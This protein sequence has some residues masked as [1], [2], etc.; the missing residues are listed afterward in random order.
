MRGGRSLLVLLVIALGLGA[1]I[2]FV[3]SERDP[4]GTEPREKVFTV[5]RSAVTSLRI[6]SGTAPATLLQRSGETWTVVEPVSA[7]A[8]VPTVD[9]ILSSLETMEVD[10]VLEESPSSVA[11]YGLEPPALEVT[12]T[13]TGGTSRTLTLGNTAPTGSGMYARSSESARLLMVPAYLKATFDKSTFDL[14]RRDV[15]DVAREAV[16]RITIVPKG[17][18]A[19]ELRREAVNWRLVSPVEARA[20]FSAVD[21]LVDRLASAQMASIA[22]EGGE[23]TAAQLRTF[24]LDAPQ[25]T[26]ALAS[27]TTTASIVFGGAAGDSRVFARDLSR[28]I[29]FTVDEALV[30]DL[31]PSADDLRVKDI[32]EFNALSA[33][34]LETAYGGATLAFERAAPSEGSPDLPSWTRTRPTAGEVN[35]TALTDLLNALSSLRAERF[36]GQAPGS[37]EDITVSVTFGTADAPR[38]EQATLRR[39]GGSVYAIR[40]GEAG[41]AIISAGEFDTVLG[42]LKTLAPSQQ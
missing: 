12:F 22:H 23:P 34:R 30:T 7:S 10:R 20:E 5:D 37:G 32:F 38:Q 40:P 42:H 31:G 6:R 13:T 35:Q 4:A 36:V 3:E 33:G 18:P 16:D 29:V 41:A 25:L 14:R 26:A 9:A 2:Y 11:A 8:D 28:P 15:L 27:G 24:G 19:I 17:Q 21:A 39:S 1:Y